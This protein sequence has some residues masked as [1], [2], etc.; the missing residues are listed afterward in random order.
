MS[1]FFLRAAVDRLHVVV[2]SCLVRIDPRTRLRIY[3]IRAHGQYWSNYWTPTVVLAGKK[4]RK[5]WR[6][7]MVTLASKQVV[8]CI[9]NSSL[10]DL[11][12]ISM[13][14]SANNYTCV[15]SLIYLYASLNT[16]SGAGAELIF[17]KKMRT[18]F[19]NKYTTHSRPWYMIHRNLSSPRFIWWIEDHL[20]CIFM[21]LDG[22]VGSGERSA[23]SQSRARSADINIGVEVVACIPH[24]SLVDLSTIPMSLSG[25]NYTRCWFSLIYLYASMNAISG[26]N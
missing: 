18:D 20:E 10:F 11:A 9:P 25:N 1:V 3:L 22:I 4:S 8:A 6:P 24:S 14:L 19:V 5:W 23:H 15:F 2:D 12:T 7:N 26:G 13:S 21:T 17:M 16:I